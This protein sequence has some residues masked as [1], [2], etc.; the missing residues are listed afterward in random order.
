[1]VDLC[2]LLPR[3]NPCIVVQGLHNECT[4]N[5]LKYSICSHKWWETLKGLIFGVSSTRAVATVDPLES[6][7]SQCRK[8]QFARCFLKAQV[9]MWN[10]LPYIVFDT[11][12]LDMFKGAVNCWLLPWVLFS[13]VFCSSGACVIVKAIYNNSIF[14]TCAAGFN[15]NNIIFKIHLKCNLII[16]II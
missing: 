16:N 15:N 4:R 3:P 1:M 13:S 8:S 2:L 12:I 10:D 5:T 14:P 9:R 7:V 6:E 11:R